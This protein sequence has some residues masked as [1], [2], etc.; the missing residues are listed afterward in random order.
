MP[1]DACAVATKGKAAQFCL[2]GRRQTLP[3]HGA[4]LR[5]VRSKYPALGSLDTH[6]SSTGGVKANIRLTA[7][8][9][10]S[11]NLLGAF[12]VLSWEDSER[13]WILLGNT[14]YHTT[15]RLAPHFVPD[16]R[17]TCNQVP[18]LLH[19]SSPG[20]YIASLKK[21]FSFFL[22]VDVVS[23]VSVTHPPI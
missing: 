16:G 8:G 18:R 15:L 14:V 1:A 2:Y 17:V 13:P 7:S 4:S 19:T 10:S 20:K 9:L 3:K 22:F 21:T 11:E 12:T 23:S 6:E 5:I